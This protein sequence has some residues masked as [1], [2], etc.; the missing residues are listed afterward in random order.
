MSVESLIEQRLS[1]GAARVDELAELV[2]SKRP[3]VGKGAVVWAANNL[4]RKGKAVRLARG[5][6][7]LSRKKVF[8]PRLTA[9]SLPLAEDISSA[10]PLLPFSLFDSAWCASFM[11]MQPFASLVSV[12]VDRSALDAVLSFLL[13]RHLPVFLKSDKAAYLRYGNAEVSYVLGRAL[14]SSPLVDTDSMASLAALEKIL[15]DLVADKDIYPQ[16][17][18]EE[19]LNIYRN[20]TGEYQVNFSRMLKYAATRGRRGEVGAVLARCGALDGEGRVAG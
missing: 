14:K 2:W 16:Y 13:G 17:Q 10:F 20:S 6:Y 9:A 18:G 1:S 4:I 5:C 11:E 19:L 8:K 7:A 15:V 3:D 12:E